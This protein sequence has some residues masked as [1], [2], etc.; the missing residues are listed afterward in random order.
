MIARQADTRRL[1][2]EPTP[3]NTAPF[4]LDATEQ[5]VFSQ[6]QYSNVYVGAVKNPSLPINTTLYNLPAAAAPSNWTSFPLPSFNSRFSYFGQASALF[7]FL[8]VGS[9]DLTDSVAAAQDLVAEGFQ[10]LV[11]GGV[12]QKSSEGWSEALEFVE[13]DDHG[14]MHARVNASVL[15]AGFVQ[16]LYALQGRRSTWW[17]GAAFSAQFTTVLWAFNDELLPRVTAGLDD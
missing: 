4:D 17:T 14:P 15:G 6:F 10:N 5:A 7:R 8:I 9:A 12:L 13:S 3:S 16:D 11:D 2:I 1:A